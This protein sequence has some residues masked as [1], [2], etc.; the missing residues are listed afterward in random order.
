MNVKLK[1]CGMR[2]AANI[3]EVAAVQPDYL[4]FIFYDQSPR[5]VGQDFDPGVLPA[6]IKR[7]G[8]FVN[9]KQEKIIRTAGE[10]QLDFV[11]LHGTETVQQCESLRAAGIDVIKAFPVDH[12]FDFDTVK[13]FR[14]CVRYVLFDTKGTYFGGNGKTFNW[15]L[16]RK[17]D[18]FIPFFLSGGL[19]PENVSDVS[20]LKNF[21]IHALDVNSGAEVAPGIKDIRKVKEFKQRI[22]SGSI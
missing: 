2:D 18:Q 4:G 3:A 11:Q 9:E 19:S 22:N 7:V 1:I 14:N 6:S 12:N 8:V 21:N 16:L 15:L 13:P 5:Y 17:Y 20:E 10:Y